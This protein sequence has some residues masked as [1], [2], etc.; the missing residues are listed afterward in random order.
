MWQVKGR[1]ALFLDRDGTLNELVFYPSSGEWESP[2]TPADLRILPGAGQALG[3]LLAEGWLLFLV[4]NQPSFAKGKT[5]LEALQAV[6]EAFETHF[7]KEGVVFTHAYYC[8]HHPQGIM[9]GY[10][11]PCPCRKPSPHFLFAAGQAYGLDL[12]SSWMVGDQDMDILCASNAG[13]KSLL[14]PAAASASKCGKQ[15]ATL[16]ISDLSLLP[17]A[18]ASFSPRR[19]LQEPS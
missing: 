9:P 4:S 2:R 12:A 10:G 19:S 11:E 8:F 17:A 5:S 15:K 6:A 13:C 14:I 16:R 3:Q 1:P 18:L 7:L